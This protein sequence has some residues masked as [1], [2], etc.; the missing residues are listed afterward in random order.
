MAALHHIKDGF[1]KLLLH[2]FLEDMKSLGA[3]CALPGNCDVWNCMSLKCCD[4]A[5]FSH[6]TCSKANMANV[7]NVVRSNFF[8]RHPIDGNLA[9]Q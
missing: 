8:K 5:I 1:A 2:T 7:A 6:Q 9:R 3:F 4:L